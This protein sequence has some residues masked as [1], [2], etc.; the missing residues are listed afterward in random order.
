MVQVTNTKKYIMPSPQKSWIRLM[1]DM[2][3]RSCEMN[4]YRKS[5]QICKTDADVSFLNQCKA[6]GSRF[7]YTILSCV[8]LKSLNLKIKHLYSNCTR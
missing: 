5:F 8:K 4:K 6:Y 7:C 1:I 3:F 2:P